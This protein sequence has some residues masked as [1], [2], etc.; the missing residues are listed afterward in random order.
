MVGVRSVDVA[1]LLNYIQETVRF[2]GIFF[3]LHGFVRNLKGRYLW[4][5]RTMWNNMHIVVFISK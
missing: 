5:H 1:V 4:Y 3:R 2:I